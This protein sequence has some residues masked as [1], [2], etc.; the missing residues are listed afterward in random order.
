[1][2]LT[3]D[4]GPRIVLLTNK[5]VITKNDGKVTISTEGRTK[6]VTVSKRSGTTMEYKIPR[7]MEV[8]VEDGKRV[9]KDVPLCGLVFDIPELQEN[10]VETGDMVQK[11][12]ALAG[13]KYSIP[14]GKRII[15]HQGDYVESGDALRWPSGSS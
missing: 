1:M 6:T 9:K 15:V 5:S 3:T 10:I 8:I 4:D 2:I 7:N 12:Q 13:R 11:G 14:S